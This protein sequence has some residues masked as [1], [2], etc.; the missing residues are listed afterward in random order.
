MTGRD[1]LREALGE[2]VEV[3]R[4]LGKPMFDVLDLDGVT[5]A[6]RT[7]AVAHALGVIEGAAV[8]LGVT[9]IE[10]LDEYGLLE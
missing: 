8:A 4:T 9:P 2:A 5:D 7:P 10:L 3:L 1:E 6:E